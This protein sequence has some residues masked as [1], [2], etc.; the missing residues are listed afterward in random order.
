MILDIPLSV[1]IDVAFN[2]ARRLVEC[3]RQYRPVAAKNIRQLIHGAPVYDRR[4]IKEA[5]KDA[6]AHH[7]KYGRG[8]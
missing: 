5:L 1:V 6:V 3:S 7:R 4:P 2:S 8:K